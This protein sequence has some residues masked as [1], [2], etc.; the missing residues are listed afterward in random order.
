LADAE[1]SGYIGHVLESMRAMSLV[2]CSVAVDIATSL[3][4]I[5]IF[6]GYGDVVRQFIGIHPE[7]AAQDDPG[8]LAEVFRANA[9]AIS[10]I[11][12]IGLDGMYEQERGVPYS[13]QKQVFEAM[14]ALAESAGKPVSIHSRRALD[15]VL[16]TLPSFR[17]KGALLHWF[18]GSKKQL[19]RSMDMDG[20]YVS[21][22]PALVYADDKKVLLKNT[23]Q[24]RFLVETD[25]PVRYARCFEGRPALPTSCLA[26]VVAAAASTIGLTFGDT[27]AL[28]QRNTETFLGRQAAGKAASGP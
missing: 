4:G 17:I 14:L 26:S 12:E 21:Y 3:K 22:G 15:D 25:G 27:A 10:G 8:K 13:W 11:G 9:P 1:Y 23:P 6:A 16:G 7:F 28:L 2:G 18:A 5:E 20:V 19:A 24:D